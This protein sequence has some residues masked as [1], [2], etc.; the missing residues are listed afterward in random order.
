MSAPVPQTSALDVERLKQ[1]HDAILLVDRN[2]KIVFANA[3]AA[4]LFGYEVDELVGSEVERLVPGR[5][6][7]GHVETRQPKEGLLPQRPQ[8]E[9]MTLPVTRK[10]GGVFDTFTGA[11]IT[12]RAIVKAVKNTLV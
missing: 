4:A 11:T 6:P 7:E 3:R 10:D 5:F 1:S 12:P 9:T 2:G 8:P